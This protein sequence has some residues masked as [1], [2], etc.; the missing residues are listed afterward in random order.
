MKRER[1]TVR[2]TAV[3]G[4]TLQGLVSGGT[5]PVREVKRAWILLKANAGW[6][7]TAIAQALEVTPATVCGV[8]R[9]FV[10]GGLDAA[11]HDLPR[12][13]R[14]PKLDEKGEAHLIALACSE[15]PEGHDHWSLRLLA[16]KAVEL[17]LT[18]SLS[19]EGVRKRLKK[20]PS[21]PGRRRS[22]AFP[23]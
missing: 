11:L 22:G 4:K 17:G 6:R 7:G 1:Y 8:K 14:P 21:S 12:P 19:H 9:R 20:T 2:L 23:R 18:D 16:G 15:A 13:G 5:H 3:Q 10:E